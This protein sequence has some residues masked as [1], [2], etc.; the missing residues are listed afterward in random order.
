SASFGPTAAIPTEIRLSLVEEP[1]PLEQ[2]R[3]LLGAHLD[4]SRREQEHL[5]GDALHAA[6]QRVREAAREVDQ[7]LREL[8]V[9]VLEVEDHRDRL[10][11]AVC[12]LLRVVE[13]ARE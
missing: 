9:G 12:D 3:A 5:V 13:A 4:V 8:R 6:V 1:A 7:P 10:L 2:L 11:E